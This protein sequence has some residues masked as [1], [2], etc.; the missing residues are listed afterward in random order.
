MNEQKILTYFKEQNHRL[1]G[2]HDTY[3]ASNASCG[4][5]VSLQLTLNDDTI[6]SVTF[7]ASACS[8]T[9]A[10]AEY[11]S[12]KIEGQSKKNISLDELKN[13]L[14]QEFELKESDKRAACALLPHRALEVVL[15]EI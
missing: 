4:D 2:T 1:Q 8:V 5:E 13:E 11:L 9:V 15:Q 3:V 7:T 12:R 6:E 14:F 10:S